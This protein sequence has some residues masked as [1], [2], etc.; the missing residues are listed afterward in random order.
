MKKT[1]GLIIIFLAISLPVYSEDKL[2]PLNNF[3]TNNNK[4]Y[5]IILGR[6]SAI[7]MTELSLTDPN[8]DKYFDDMGVLIK[9]NQKFIKFLFPGENETVDAQN[10]IGLH[11]YFVSLYQKDFNKHL[12]SS[13]RSF[14]EKIKKKIK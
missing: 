4:Q 13:D 7:E 5:S 8:P 9:E 12:I 10:A 6:C 14:C 11:E 2:Q 1:L 3:D